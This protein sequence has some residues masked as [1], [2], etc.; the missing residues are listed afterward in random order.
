MKIFA[1]GGLILLLAGLVFPWS[2]ASSQDQQLSETEAKEIVASG[3]GSIID[4]DVAHA[5]DD[6]V[7]DAL[8]TGIEQTLGL[9]LESETLVENFQLIEDNIFSKT[10]G[11]VQTYEVIREG[12]RNEYLYE[13]TVKAIVKMTDLK[14]D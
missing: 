5:R 11:Y 10:K 1:R 8:R 14:N 9:L 7:E 4:G 2:G 12:K 13:V 6:A 3:M